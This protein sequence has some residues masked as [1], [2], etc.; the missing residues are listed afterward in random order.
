MLHKLQYCVNPS[1]HLREAS[2]L[3]FASKELQTDELLKRK[4]KLRNAARI[5]L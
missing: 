5:Q 1:Q 3:L 2:S 4:T